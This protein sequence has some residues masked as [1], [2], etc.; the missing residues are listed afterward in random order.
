[1]RESSIPTTCLTNARLTVR[2]FF[3]SLGCDCNFASKSALTYHLKSHHSG[4]KAKKGVQKG[5]MS[6]S[7]FNEE[8]L[9]IVN[10]FDSNPQ[11]HSATNNNHFISN[12][13]SC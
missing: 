3:N 6:R 7:K 11:L 8:I 12:Y 5:C 10:E 1:M 13:F 4:K 2:I 9:K